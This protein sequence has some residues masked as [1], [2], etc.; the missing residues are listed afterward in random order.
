MVN[1][2]F[3]YLGLLL[4][5]VSTSVLA[6]SPNE[7]HTF[8]AW[9]IKSFQADGVYRAFGD[10]VPVEFKYSSLSKRI[11]IVFK[12]DDLEP[13]SLIFDWGQQSPV[14]KWLFERGCL[15]LP[16]ADT[17]FPDNSLFTNAKATFKHKTS[18]NGFT[19]YT[20]K[21]NRRVLVVDVEPFLFTFEIR[22]PVV[23]GGEIVI[24]ESKSCFT[25]ISLGYAGILENTAKKSEQAS[26]PGPDICERKPLIE[27]NRK[28]TGGSVKHVEDSYAIDLMEYK[29]LKERCKDHP[30]C[31]ASI[32]SSKKKY[33]WYCGGGRGEPG[34]PFLSPTDK[35]CDMHDRKAWSKKRSDLNWCG[36]HHALTCRRSLPEVKAWKACFILDFDALKIIQAYALYKAKGCWKTLHCK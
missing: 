16:M 28:W 32:T 6:E 14:G 25:P 19:A 20:S 24:P 15:E 5:C 3:K 31:D 2:V 35:A 33:G 29:T 17:D 23:L 27:A 12:D 22:D 13:S 18:I 36:L 8:M 34:H 9:G 26:T 21:N 30:K 4:F 10:E 7:N 11:S 1:T